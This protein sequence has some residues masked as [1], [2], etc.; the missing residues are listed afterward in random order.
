V[1]SGAVSR[2]GQLSWGSRGLQGPWVGQCRCR[3]C[4]RSPRAVRSGWLASPLPPWPSPS[5]AGLRGVPLAPRRSPFR[6]TPRAW[7]LVVFAPLQSSLSDLAVRAPRPGRTS[8]ASPGI[9]RGCAPKRLAAHRPS[10]DTPSSVHSHG[11][12]SRPASATRCHPRRPV[13]PSWF[14]TTS[15][16]S[17]ARSVAGLL[18]PAADP[19]VR[20]V[21]PGRLLHR[22]TTWVTR[23]SRLPRSPRRPF[24]PL[25]DSPSIAAVPRHR[26]RCLRGVGPPLPGRLAPGRCRPRRSSFL[27]RSSS[28]SR[29]CSAIE[30]RS[31]TPPLPAAR[32]LSFLGFV[33]LRGTFA[34]RRAS[35]ADDRGRSVPRGGRTRRAAVATR[36]RSDRPLHRRTEGKTAPSTT[37]GQLALHA[38][39]AGCA[40]RKR[41]TVLAG[42][43]RS[44]G[45]AVTWTCGR[46]IPK[47][48]D[49]IPPGVRGRVAQAEARAARWR[50]R[51]LSGAEVHDRLPALGSELPPGVGSARGRGP[52]WG[53]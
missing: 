14:R 7:T 44:G 21:S 23:P 15:A 42:A 30:V 11:P 49:S 3:C 34:G 35:R 24:T 12:A 40:R 38:L 33:P 1:G 2:A 45:P 25:E 20:P 13:P 29:P 50:P 16:A 52:P 26:G 31:A 22:V 4:A 8:A 41:R 27:R 19:G 28:P 17:S 48:S 5:P 43:P 6:R 47:R 53:L 37:D 39:V 36:L 9:R 32:A 10:V 18:H 51:S 46:G